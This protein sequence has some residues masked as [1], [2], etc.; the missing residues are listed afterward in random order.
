MCVAVRCVFLLA[1]ALAAAAARAAEDPLRSVACTEALATLEAARGAGG[2]NVEPLRRSAARACLGLE[3][4]PV[5]SARPIE[6]P[7]S[8]PPPAIAPPG[9]PAALLQP[10]PLPPPVPIE[11]PPFVTACDLHGCWTNDGTRMQRIAPGQAGPRG[12]CTLQAGVVLCP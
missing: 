1:L 11:R 10:S 2:A 8:V 7:T 12:P 6:P 4:P 3:A 5:R 9:A